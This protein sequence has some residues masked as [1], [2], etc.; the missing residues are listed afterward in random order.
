[1]AASYFYSSVAVPNSLASPVDGVTT[2]ATL[3]STP[4]GYPS[5]YPFKAV[6]DPG[7]GSEEIVYVTNITGVTVTMTRGREGTAGQSHD[8]GAVFQHMVTGKDLQDS[9]DHEDATVAHGATG[10]VVG[11]TNAQALTNKTINGGSNT[12]ADVPQSAITD[13]VADLAAIDAELVVIDT[14]QGVQ[15]AA[16]TTHAADT[17][18]HGVGVV[19]GTTEAQALTNKTI[20][21]DDNTIQDVPLAALEGHQFI[22]HKTADESV[23]SSTTLQ[24][25]DHL[26][27]D[28]SVFPKLGVGLYMV[29][30]CVFWD[31][32]TAGDIK[33]RVTTTTGSI[34]DSRFQVVTRQDSALSPPFLITV[35]DEASE[36]GVPGNGV[37]SVMATTITGFVELSAATNFFRFRWAQNASSASA[38]RVRKG[39][40][41]RVTKVA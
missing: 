22:V 25:D 17:S 36:L 23:V 16:L 1:V 12:L 27:V 18:T 33:F 26:V 40:W 5:S 11:T 38:T 39:S 15:D 30:L 2:T 24:N 28:S 34:T 14:E 6:L 9:R 29:E 10:A 3:G 4:V 13:L 7:T 21:G 32:A 8:S 20:D 41:M 35:I 19:V 31:A 37:G